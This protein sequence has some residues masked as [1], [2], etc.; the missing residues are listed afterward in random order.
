[1]SAK[2]KL[3]C[4]HKCS[5]SKSEHRAFDRGFFAAKSSKTDSVKNPF[6]AGTTEWDAFESGASAGR[7]A[8]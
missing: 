5:H 6:R 2:F 7:C 4:G 8:L 3:S 1:M